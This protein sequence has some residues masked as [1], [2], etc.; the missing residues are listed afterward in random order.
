[1]ANGELTELERWRM[2]V[3]RNSG[4]Y[5]EYLKRIIT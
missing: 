2:K 1:M 3:F 4:A 5:G